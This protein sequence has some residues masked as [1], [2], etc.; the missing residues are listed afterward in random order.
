MIGRDVSLKVNTPPSG[1]TN[2][3]KAELRPLFLQVASV[4]DSVTTNTLQL[5]DFHHFS[6]GR[7]ELQSR[8]KCTNQFN[9]P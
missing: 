2:T 9:E 4:D 5:I 7:A 3:R 6:L 1:T 8:A